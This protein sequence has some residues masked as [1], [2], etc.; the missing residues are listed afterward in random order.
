MRPAYMRKEINMANLV[1]TREI[2]QPA[3]KQQISRQSK[4]CNNTSHGKTSYLVC[5][6]YGW[7]DEWMDGWT[8]IWLDGTRWVVDVI[9]GT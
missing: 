1:L 9:V 4:L 2:T 7:I 5:F 6:S 3:Q 8:F